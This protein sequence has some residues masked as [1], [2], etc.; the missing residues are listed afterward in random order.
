M[1]LGLFSPPYA[2]DYA[3]GRRTLREV[4]EW[5]IQLARWADEYGLSELFFAEHHTIGHEPSPAPDLMIAAASRETEQL[6]LGA[7]AHLLPYHNPVALAQRLMYLDH[8]TGGR[9]IAGFAP[10]SFPTDGQLFGVGPGNARM[11]DEALTIIE[12]IWTAERPFR[13]DGEFWTVDMPEHSDQWNGPH[14]RPFQQ[15]RPEILMTGVQPVS[16]TLVDAGRRGYS[17]MSQ[18]VGVAVLRTQWETYAQAATEAG[19]T[20]DRAN[21]RVM[22]DVFV[23]ESDRE[24]RRLFLEEPAGRTWDELVLPTFRAVRDRGGK[25][26]ALG[27]LLVGPGMTVEEL[28]LDWMVD[29]FLIIGSPDTVVEKIT[30]FSGEIGGVGT[31]LSFAFDFSREPEPYRRHL[32]LLGREVAPRIAN[33]GAPAVAEA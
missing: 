26:Y 14:L 25:P 18:E 10:G 2:A 13:I 33:L 9:Y 11:M 15:P 24:A 29:H 27:E 8:M 31:L 12:A 17:P 3:A 16:P 32:E 22:R 21:W 30:E 28:T 23:A 19:R 20:P 1:D 4:I 5:D 7:A 6:R